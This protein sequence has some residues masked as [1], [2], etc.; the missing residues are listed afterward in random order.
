MLIIYIIFLG[1]AQV[2]LAE[3]LRRHTRNVLYSVRAGSS[4]AV[5]VFLNNPTSVNAGLPLNFF[6]LINFQNSK[7]IYYFKTSKFTLEYQYMN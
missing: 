5:D 7:N 3:W 6:I 2:D 1:S 4:P